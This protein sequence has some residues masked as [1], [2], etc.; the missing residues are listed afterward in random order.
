MSNNK[1]ENQVIKIFLV[2]GQTTGF[3]GVETVL[4]KFYDLFASDV[5]FDCQFLICGTPKSQNSLAWLEGANY[6]QIATR[7][8]SRALVKAAS[9]FRIASVIKREKPDFIIG[10]DAFGV[11]IARKA[12]D[13]SRRKV[14]LVAWPHFSFNSFSDKNKKRLALADHHFAIC[15]EIKAQMRDFGI[16]KS[17]IHT[18]YN[19]TDRVDHCLERPTDGAKF[20]YVGRVEY[21]SGKNLK[22]L[23]EALSL[24]NGEFSLDIV[25]SGKDDDLNKL[26]QLA[27][28]LGLSERIRF[29]GWQKA[30]WEYVRHHIK[31]V[32]CL[33]MTSTHEGFGMV[34]IEAMSHGVYCISSDC[35]T[36]PSDIIRRQ[37]NGDLYSVGDS[38]ALSQQLQQIIDGKALPSSAVIKHS[39]E[40]L[41]DDAYINHIKGILQAIRYENSQG[42][43]SAELEDDSLAVE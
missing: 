8:Y 15:D 33:V 20:L 3:G 21:Q 2:A 16:E 22:E 25:G 11:E 1:N 12:I 23:F 10:Y 5:K 19:S 17:K 36:G 30:P 18:V 6:R 34:L 31:Q 41:Y 40:H 39:I 24:L 38:A 4:R 13:L 42:E 7:L 32:N 27:Q 35:P 37:T 9:Q 43:L 26:Y 28:T 29:H 14:N